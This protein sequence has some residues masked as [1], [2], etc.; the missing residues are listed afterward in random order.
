[1]QP[2]EEKGGPF[3]GCHRQQRVDAAPREERDEAVHRQVRVADRKVGHVPERLQAAKC[4]ERALRRADEIVQDTDEK[5][6]QCV[7]AA[8]ARR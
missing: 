3:A 1:M 4:L 7:R 2:H 8:D 5:E 6:R